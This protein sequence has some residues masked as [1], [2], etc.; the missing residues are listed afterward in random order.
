M[1]VSVPLTASEDAVSTQWAH[2]AASARKVICW[3][4]DAGARV[5]VHKN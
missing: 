2:T 3:S 1:S 5:N 4:V